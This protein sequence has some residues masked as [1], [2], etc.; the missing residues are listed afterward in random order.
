MKLLVSVRDA[1]EALLAAGAGADIV[2]CKEP[3]HGALGALPLASLRAVV[4]ALRRG[5]PGL[6]ISATVG[7]FAPGEVDAVLARAAATAACGVDYV[8]VGLAPGG[9]ALLQALGDSGLRVVPVFLADD[10]LDL[11]LLE[12]ALA[13]PFAAL[14]LDTANKASGSLFERLPEPLLASF[15][16]RVRAAGRL[17]GLAGALRERHLPQ[18]E[19]LAPHIAGFRG[20]VCQGGRS[21]TLDAALVRRL[22]GR[23]PQGLHCLEPLKPHPRVV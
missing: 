6:T 23:L 18:L 21:G 4:A 13:L 5:H 17:C 20:A 15:V 2:D 16:A 7:D 22:R 3:R 11:G 19:R 1:A 14:M 8:K 10:G 12:Q 9:Q